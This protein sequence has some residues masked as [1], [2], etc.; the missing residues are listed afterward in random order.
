M[1][2]VKDGK[3]FEEKYI[4]NDGKSKKIEINKVD[5]NG[6]NTFCKDSYLDNNYYLR[7][8]YQNG[9]IVDTR[10]DEHKKGRTKLISVEII[11]KKQ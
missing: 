5:S 2:G 8:E 9:I 3:E 6:H 10:Q 7:K 4:S 11:G 1:R